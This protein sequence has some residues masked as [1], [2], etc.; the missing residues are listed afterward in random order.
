VVAFD[1]T[2]ADDSVPEQI[3]YWALKTSNPGVVQ[4]LAGQ[5]EGVID[6]SLAA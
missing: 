4:S 5:I 3:R 1:E 6:W 2:A